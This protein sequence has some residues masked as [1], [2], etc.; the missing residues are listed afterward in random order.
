MASVKKMEER[1]N[2]LVAEGEALR[3]DFLNGYRYRW[4]SYSPL[5]AGYSRWKK[6]CLGLVEEAF[7]PQ[8]RYYT[9]LAAVERDYSSRAPNSVFTFFFN[10]VRNALREL[11]AAPGPA[12]Q[13]SEADVAEDF[14][15]RAEG[16]AG[17]AHYLSAATLA[18]AVLEDALRRLCEAND[19][20]CAENS[21][22]DN[23]NDRLL[24]AG[25]YD[26]AWHRETALRIGLKR[27]AELCYV[28]KITENNVR[29]MIAWLRGFM[30]AHFRA[31]LPARVRV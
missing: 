15:A 11:K 12:R 26:S 4:Y 18:G 17:K 16:L 24:Q 25:V 27:T 31:G 23:V 3:E 10:T 28:E 9:E 30:R 14:L 29:E 13:P 7:G 6:D 1:F 5:N 8:S 19:V 21:T 2:E 22:L 20:F